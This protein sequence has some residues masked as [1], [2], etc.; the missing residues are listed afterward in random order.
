MTLVSESH[1]FVFLHVPKSGGTSITD[2]LVHLQSP[3]LVERLRSE[4][5]LRARDLSSALPEL[6][7]EDLFVF[8]FVRHPYDHLA[9]WWTYLMEHPFHPQ[10]ADTVAAGSFASWVRLHAERPDVLQRDYTH[11]RNGCALIDFVGHHERIEEDFAAVLERIGCGPIELPHRNASCHR[12]RADLFDRQTRA[13]VAER[14]KL[15]FEAF[16]YES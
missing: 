16:G 6:C 2:A 8:A 3:C 14:W 5:H 13:F 11:D 10:Y 4:K 9:S 7:V 15:D 1:R 12:D